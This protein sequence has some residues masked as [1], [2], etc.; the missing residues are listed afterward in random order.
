MKTISIVT[1]CFNEEEGIENC[2]FAIEMIFHAHL[3]N[4]NL[5]HIICDNAS[6]DKTVEK[7]RELVRSHPHVR[8]IVNSRNFGILKNT[9]NGVM[10]AS[11]DAIFL[12]MPVDLQ[13]PPELIPKFVKHWEDGYEIVYGLRAEREE[14]LI[15]RTL[16]KLYYRLLS[17]LSY[18]DY[19]AD[20]GDFQLIDRRVLEAMK[21]VRDAQP[22]MRMM[23]FDAGF[24]SIGVKYTWRGR[25]RGKS[26]NRLRDMIDQGL[27]GLI[28]FSN[29]PVRFALF[30]GFITSFCSAIYAIFI[31]T[32]GLIGK[33]SAPQG[34]T[35]IIIALFFFGGVQILITG[36]IGEYVIAIFNQVRI[37]PLVNER[38]R[39]N[40]DD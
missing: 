28:S 22:F 8:V 16:R 35:T 33:I 19:P 14:P 30:G 10:N 39:I 26:R 25:E 27:N 29:A 36:L 23:T 17:G 32:L 15:W 13:D 40:W 18:V 7:L 38:E 4:Y 5:E 12:F 20:A 6:T 1:P 3:Q 24:S 21:Q 31:L 11:G 2:I 34:T 37:R 9:Y